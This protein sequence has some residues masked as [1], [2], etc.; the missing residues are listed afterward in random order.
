MLFATTDRREF[1]RQL[2]DVLSPSQA[3]TDPAHLK[4]RASE[5]RGTLEALEMPGRHVLI[6]GLRGVGKSSLALTTA[7]TLSG[8]KEAYGRILSS[9]TRA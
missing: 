2:R 5:Y 4:G 7:M 6:C 1:A 8:A 9:R 3:I